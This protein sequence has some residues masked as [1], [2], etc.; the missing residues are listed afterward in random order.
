[1]LKQRDAIGLCRI[2]GHDQCQVKFT[3]NEETGEIIGGPRS[4]EGSPL[5]TWTKVEGCVRIR[6]Y[7]EWNNHADR[8]NYP[9]KRA[10]KRGENKWKQISWDQAFDEIADKLREIKEV[11]GPEKLA[12][13]SGFYNSQWDISRFANLYGTP[14]IDS[15]N[16]R[17]C[18]G[19]EYWVNVLVY[20]APAH[21]GPPDPE[22]CQL[23]VL[24]ANRPSSQ[25][26]IKWASEKKVPHRIV[27][28]P[29]W[30]DECKG[31]DFWL[32]IRPGTDSALALAWLNVIINE[33]LY[34]KQFVDR[35]TVGFD[36]LKERVQQYDPRKVSEITG[37]PAKDIV[38]SAKLYATTKPASIIWGSPCGYS[39]LNAARIEQARCCLRAITGNIGVVGGNHFNVTYSKQK[40]LHE[41]ELADRM[42]TDK[43][44]KALGGGKYRAMTW[45]GYYMVPEKARGYARSFVN[46]GAPMV[47]IY[48]AM[49]TGAPHPI[50]GA[51]VTACNPMA[52]FSQA[53]HVYEALMN[54]EFVVCIDLIHTPTTML[55]DYVLPATSWLESP[56]IGYLEFKYILYTG[57]RCLPKSIPG[58]Y[59]RRDDYDIWR[60]LGIRLGQ[61][62]D[63]PWKTLEEVYDWRIEPTG[64][65]FKEFSEKKL[66]DIEPLVD[67]EY[68]KE[69]FDTR[70]GKVEL[71]S[72]I[73]EDLG[74]DPLP[75][76]EEPPESPIRTPDLAKK[77]PL[78]AI[79]LKSQIFYQSSYRNN[80]SL[81]KLHPDPLVEINKDVAAKEGI[82]D[83]DWVHVENQNGRIRMKA[84]VT[85]TIRPDTV[86]LDFGWWY[87]EKEG[88]EPSLFG[89]WESNCNVLCS[90]DLEYAGREC[91][92][93]HLSTF[94]VKTN[95]VKVT[96]AD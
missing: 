84:K 88:A 14:N 43:I 93:W 81:R 74:Y 59:D 82:N 70:S 34:D 54:T 40:P 58:K 9:V 15:L 30:I 2:Q 10:G 53:R 90:D 4:V 96:K 41:L 60:E 78:I 75:Y 28:D 5:T 13:L 17:I 77:Y 94:M 45:P 18:G 89:I 61:E 62:K 51:I 56:Q 37:I 3:V 31:A 6:H 57:Q 85:E 35:W 65:T 44:T 11:H 25:F 19:L 87:P 52:T 26:P 69:G 47:A 49:R 95:R 42:P 68:E 83:G 24:W 20:G 38:A 8:L 16:A 63:W 12:L 71:A 79:T 50:K 22:K 21:Y 39:G 33:N 66:W 36:R 67:R 80:A 46:R 72:S 32:K 23:V 86:C 64:M 76:Y 7:L 27:I 55:A 29:R 73:F 48:N 91:G 1:M 92:N